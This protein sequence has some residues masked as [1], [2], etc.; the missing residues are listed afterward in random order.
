MVELPPRACFLV[1]SKMLDYENEIHWGLNHFDD[2]DSIAT[3][4]VKFAMIA[5]VLR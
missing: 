3:L 2:S 5:I 1:V 4:S